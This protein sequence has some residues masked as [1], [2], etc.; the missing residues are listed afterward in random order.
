[1]MRSSAILLGSPLALSLSPRGA[2]SPLTPLSVPT[3]SSDVS[4]DI[5]R[6][7]LNQHSLAVIDQVRTPNKPVNHR[8]LSEQWRLLATH[9][10]D[11]DF[12]T[13]MRSALPALVQSGVF[14]NIAQSSYDD[15]INSALQSG[16]PLRREQL[17]SVLG[18]LPEGDATPLVEKLVSDG[19]S[20]YC[21][22]KADTFKLIASYDDQVTL[23]S[24]SQ[25]RSAAHLI[26][27]SCWKGTTKQ[28]QYQSCVIGET[29]IAV[30]IMSLGTTA[31]LLIPACAASLAAIGAV[32][33]VL[34]VGGTTAALAAWLQSY[35][36]NPIL[37]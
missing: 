35:Y 29:D 8:A 20:T 32:G 3:T 5:T 12:D 30:I 2:A 28:E 27:V 16:A 18:K 22:R 24:Y 31:C 9:F 13:K 19:M 23:S 37:S 17:L 34:A 11:T 33:G 25:H 10:E 14:S 26:R 4:T 15:V 7:V 1:V 21:H 6:Y 36:C